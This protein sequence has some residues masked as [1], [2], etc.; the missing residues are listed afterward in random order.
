[1]DAAADH[2]FDRLQPYWGR[3]FTSL[4]FVICSLLSV[5]FVLFVRSVDESDTSYGDRIPYIDIR[6]GTERSLFS[7]LGVVLIITG[8]WRADRTWDEEGSKAVLAGEKDVKKLLKVFPFPWT[9]LLGW[10]ILASSY[11]FDHKSNSITI[12]TALG[13]FGRT[14]T[15]ELLE[16]PDNNCL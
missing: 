9:F 11:L 8:V 10:A 4:F 14:Y 12:G 13:T 1:M 15:M 16:S 2:V 6:I 3:I 7:L 5:A